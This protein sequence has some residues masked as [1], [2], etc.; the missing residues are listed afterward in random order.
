MDSDG[1]SKF[2]E[3]WE[4]I[5]KGDTDKLLELLTSDYDVNQ[6]D[7]YGTTL[8]DLAA[9]KSSLEM[10][11]ILLDA[12]AEI[13]SFDSE[14]GTPLMGA[15]EE[16]RE[17]VVEFLLGQGADPN[18]G[19]TSCGMPLHYAARNGDVGIGRLLLEH[20][21]EV[22]AINN[23]ADCWTPL[24]SAS[25]DNRLEFAKLLVESGADIYAMAGL[26]WPMDVALYH[27]HRDVAEYLYLIVENEYPGSLGTPLHAAA[28][29]REI[30]LMSQFTDGNY[31]TDIRD[32]ASRTPLH[33]AAG[34]DRTLFFKIILERYEKAQAF[35]VPTDI[36]R[37]DS[38]KAIEFLLGKGA[39]IEAKDHANNTPLLDALQWGQE[40]A[41]EILISRGADV[42]AT[43][44]TGWT[45]VIL[46][47]CGGRLG[48]LKTLVQRGANLNAIRRDWNALNYACHHGKEEA[49]RFL[50]DCGM[51]VNGAKQRTRL[52][53]PLFSAIF[54]GHLSIVKLLLE[55]G[56]DASLKNDRGNTAF[57]LA[58]GNKK[59]LSLLN[60]H[61]VSK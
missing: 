22:N 50:L 58:H 10:I 34:E 12:G 1:K 7:E 41:A 28:G 46:A 48:V 57:S 26:G 21:A 5:D 9:R 40:D 36:S 38:R 43:D 29:L 49:A 6:C 45:P 59:I 42:N 30:G 52:P 25:F 11:R 56:A 13:N 17:D 31:E 61:G 33:W 39:D 47:A 16:H 24:H 23:E 19:T 18:I 20:G 2:M 4:I 44:N 60:D 3:L 14:G 55:R 37:G 15:V 54:M 53:Y 32:Y 35:K 8:L 51:D 27:G